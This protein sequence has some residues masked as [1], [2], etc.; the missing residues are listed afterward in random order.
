MKSKKKPHR[1]GIT[2]ECSEDKLLPT[3]D[4]ETGEKVD[5]NANKVGKK[6][7][8]LKVGFS[9]TVSIIIC[10]FLAEICRC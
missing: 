5:N 1:E 7:K 10:N 9:E 3:T 8:A 2:T 6:T 4:E